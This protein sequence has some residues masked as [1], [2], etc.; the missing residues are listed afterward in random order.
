[1]DEMTAKTTLD[2]LT[3]LDGC[4]C[5]ESTL[6]RYVNQRLINPLTVTEFAEHLADMK[7]KGWVDSRVNDFRKKVWWITGAGQVQRSRM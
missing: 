7:A 4:A 3:A 2:V 5:E 1:M 6:K